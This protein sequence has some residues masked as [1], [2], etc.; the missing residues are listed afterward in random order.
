MQAKTVK[1]ITILQHATVEG[2][3]C[4]ACNCADFDCFKALPEVVEFEGKLCGKTGW[5]SDKNL[6]YYQSNARIALTIPTKESIAFEKM[7][8]D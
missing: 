8:D 2:T 7:F 4:L 6:A 5:N 3:L 1:G